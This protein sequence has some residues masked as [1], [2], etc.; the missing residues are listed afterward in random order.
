MYLEE[1]SKG[2]IEELINKGKQQGG[3]S[4]DEINMCLAEEA[5]SPDMFS[6]VLSLMN[7]HGIEIIENPSLNYGIIYDEEEGATGEDVG[8]LVPES[9]SIDLSDGKPD[10]DDEL[11]AVSQ[12][13]VNMKAHLGVP[14]KM[15][16]HQM[17]MVELLSRD[18]EINIAE[19]IENNM[20]NVMRK[21]GF[22][23][24]AVEAI[25]EAHFSAQKKKGKHNEVCM[26]LYTEDDVNMDKQ[27]AKVKKNITTN[28]SIQKRRSNISQRMKQLRL[29]MNKM[30]ATL[31]TELEKTKK[32]RA[33]HGVNHKLMRKQQEK[34]NQSFSLMKLQ[35]QYYDALVR[36]VEHLVLTILKA[37]RRIMDIAV[38]QAGYDEK[39][40]KRKLLNAKYFRLIAARR[41][42]EAAII[43]K[44]LDTLQRA[45]GSLIRVALSHDMP[46]QQIKELG[47]IIIASHSQAL[48]AKKE[49]VEANLRLVIS[50]AKKYSNRGLQLLDLIQE[51]NMGL[52]K[53]VDKFEYKRGYKFSTYATW[54]IRQAVTRSIADQARTI[55]IPVHMI[56]TM[57]R[58][59]RT[60]RSMMQRLGR[61]PSPAEL[62]KEMELP[63]DKIHR[64]L[65]IAK[66]TV[67]TET[68]LG[69]DEDAKLQ[70]IIEDKNA[71]TPFQ[72]TCYSELRE[73][74]TDALS[75]LSD[76]E[77]KVLNMRFPL[78]SRNDVS[79]DEL[80][81]QYNLTRDNIRQ[82]EQRAL[83][84][85]RALSDMEQAQDLVD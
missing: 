2:K 73:K 45:Q 65:K 16:M 9:S 4:Y 29:E 36:S 48:R 56:E 1:D 72:N 38:K 41:G 23:H 83:R 64:M 54:W 47:H 51:G 11:A 12:L 78:T 20:R 82:I 63:E 61:D 46:L 17:G 6:E 75:S 84:R 76:P 85:L 3:L 55:R 30:M 77:A 79:I 58:L 27:I 50:V 7:S 8:S 70:D 62:A 34:L 5:L 22:F 71:L 31:T 39:T 57:N 33:K 32:C 26:A 81:K 21:M 53:A 67:S 25:L 28:V 69:E 19:R 66:E 18:Q 49:M 14:M 40:I 52:M 43:K 13:N 42:R 24:T 80:T 60:Q 35:P 74:M 68:P 44:K 10:E 15:Y 59:S 37:E